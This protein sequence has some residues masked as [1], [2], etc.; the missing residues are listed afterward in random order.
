MGSYQPGKDCGELGQPKVPGAEKRNQVEDSAANDVPMKDPP[1]R[2][3]K[4][5]KKVGLPLDGANHSTQV[6]HICYV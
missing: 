3:A 5:K 6:Q 2:E 4:L 1:K